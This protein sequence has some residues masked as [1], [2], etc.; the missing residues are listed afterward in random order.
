M[1]SL[2]SQVADLG[3]ANKTLRRYLE[4]LVG[5]ISPAEAS[6]I[7]AEEQQRLEE[8]SLEQK[9]KSNRLIEYLI[10]YDFLLPVIRRALETAETLADFRVTLDKSRE[11]DP[12]YKRPVA[13][14]PPMWDEAAKD[15]NEARALLDK[16]SLELE[17]G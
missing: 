4:E 14:G 16:P 13:L 12:D 15:L 17:G 6:S 2:A 3:E 7:I 1:A 5:K 9:L 11:G 10:T 8:A